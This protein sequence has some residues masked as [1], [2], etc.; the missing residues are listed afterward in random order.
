MMHTTRR[1]LFSRSILAAVLFGSMALAA[2]AAPAQ[3]PSDGANI[4]ETQLKSR[5]T[6]IQCLANQTV[7]LDGALLKVDSPAIQATGNCH[8]HITNSRVV[9]RVAVAASGNAEIAFEN[10]IVEGSL[11]LTGN[12]VASFKSST[13][14]GRIRKLQSGGVKDLGHNLWH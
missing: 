5:T 4:D 1:P 12:S 2:V 11:S 7:D 10:C 3:A 6:P 14:R 13:V 8:V 9:G